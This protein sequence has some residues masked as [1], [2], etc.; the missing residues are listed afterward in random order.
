V[1]KRIFLAFVFLGACAQHQSPGVVSA[2]TAE[3]AKPAAASGK[4]SDNAPSLYVSFGEKPG[5]TAI[6]D[7]FA[8]HV[9]EDNRVKRRFAESDMV[10]F[11]A[12]AVEQMCQGTGGPCVYKGKDMK[13]A[14]VGLGITEAEYDAVTEDLVMALDEQHVPKDAQKRFLTNR[15][16]NKP[17]IIEA[18]A[19]N[20]SLPLPTDANDPVLLRADDLRDAAR[21]LDLAEAARLRGSRALAGKLFNSVEMVVGS[22]FLADL[23][24]LFQ[25][26]APPRVQTPLHTLPPTTEPQP[27]VVTSTEEPA[28]KPRAP[29]GPS[30]AGTLLVG[31]KPVGEGLG[32]VTLTPLDRPAKAPT[33]RTRTMEQRNRQF[34]PHLMVVPVGST[35]SFPNFDPIYHNVY[36]VSDA[37]PFD[38]GVYKNGQTR[39]MVLDKPGVLHLECNIHENMSA[40]IVVVAEPYH[41]VAEAGH[42]NFRALPQ[43]RYRLRAWNEE[44]QQ[45]VTQEV[46]VKAGKN[47][48]SVELGAPAGPVAH[49]EKYSKAADAAR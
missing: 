44:G 37:K 27:H 8:A 28:S 14:H 43:G 9:L 21:V 23:L 4:P 15:D 40:Y 13:T 42:F 29:N 49:S 46:V 18:S 32:V 5:I 34:A 1:A 41:A 25:T 45:T 38:L 36:S 47:V 20:K 26:G 22:A 6:V 16:K 35:V 24:P 12:M 31:G 33:P 19:S 30:L 2:T 17:K 10:H 11:K 39:E 48:V 3:T 7:R